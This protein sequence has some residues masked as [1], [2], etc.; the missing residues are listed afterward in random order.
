MRKTIRAAA[1]ALLA[2]STGG[3]AA[4]AADM[5]M[6]PAYDERMSRPDGR[7]SARAGICGATSTTRYTEMPAKF[8]EP[9]DQL[10]LYGLPAAQWLDPGLAALR[11]RPRRR[12]SV[13]QLA[14]RRSSPPGSI[15]VSQALWA[16][17]RVQRHDSNACGLGRGP[18]RQACVLSV[19]TNSSS[20]LPQYTYTA[21]SASPYG[22]LTSQTYLLNGYVDL[23]TWFGITPYVGAGAAFEPMLQPMSIT[24]TWTGHLTATAGTTPTAAA[25]RRHS[26]GASAC[27]YYGYPNNMRADS[28]GIISHGR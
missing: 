21:C 18:G 9:T 5:N 12:L 27:F 19:T 6:P 20:G 28:G 22:S 25:I 16:H 10:A 13:Q 26:G 24:N 11:R 1:A 8:P 14:P 15:N 7:N 4:R 3:L 2:W 17:R 23:G